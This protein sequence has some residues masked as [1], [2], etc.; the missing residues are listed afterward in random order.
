VAELNAFRVVAR[1]RS[2]T[3]G[4]KLLHTSQST[5]SRRIRLL[6]DKLQVCLLSR[7][8]HGLEL[9]ESGRRLLRH[10]DRLCLHEDELMADLR[11]L[12]P[13]SINGLLRVGAP[14]S[15]LNDVVLPSIA[16]MLRANP[17]V[18][19]ELVCEEGARVDRLLFDG[20]ADLV[21][22]GARQPR[23]GNV[24]TRLGTEVYVLLESSRFREC[25]AATLELRAPDESSP[26]FPPTEPAAALRGGVGDTHALLRAVEHGLG[27][28]LVPLHV[29][30]AHSP[31]QRVRDAPPCVVERFI[32]HAS[33][34]RHARLVRAIVDCLRARAGDFLA[35][36]SKG[37]L[38][39]G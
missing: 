35:R 27:R 39:G 22:S 24:A 31:V 36:D 21:V 1:E 25:D 23:R 32:H 2:F 7:S 6:E 15:L 9:T 3:L 8:V 34:A 28:A 11:G 30:P 12:H 4:A 10:A 33:E 26:G 29:V 5:L 16:P 37:L 17:G 38:A 13:L 19:V 14:S 20:R 18:L